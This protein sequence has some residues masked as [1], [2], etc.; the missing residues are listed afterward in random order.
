MLNCLYCRVCL[1]TK[2]FQMRNFW[3]AWVAIGM[4][5]RFL[6]YRSVDFFQIQI[7]SLI[8]LKSKDD[9]SGPSINHFTPKNLADYFPLT[10]YEV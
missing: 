6:I 1:G 3:L 2:E 9:S 10:F 4:K 7:P 8:N 5:N